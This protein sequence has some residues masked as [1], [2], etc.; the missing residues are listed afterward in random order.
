MVIWNYVTPYIPTI[1]MPQ[2]KLELNHPEPA[3]ANW[4]SATLTR[5]KLYIY[6]EMLCMVKVIMKQTSRSLPRGLFSYDMITTRF[7]LIGSSVDPLRIDRGYNILHRIYTQFLDSCFDFVP[8]SFV[9]SI[10]PY[11]PWLF[12]CIG[13]IVRLPLQ[14]QTGTDIVYRVHKMFDV[15]KKYICFVV[16]NKNAVDILPPWVLCTILSYPAAM[17]LSTVILLSFL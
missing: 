3:P 2:N 12:Y 16:F 15:I 13:K 1:F 17:L 10:N 8:G 9:G 7:R 4:M 14:C 6:S 11:S 5:T